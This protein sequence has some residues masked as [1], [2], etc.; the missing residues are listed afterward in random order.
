MDETARYIRAQ[1]EKIN[2]TNLR[3]HIFKLKK[4]VH[5]AWWVN[6]EYVTVNRKDLELLLNHMKQELKKESN[7]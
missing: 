6:C 4:L 7:G 5:A 1:Q 2:Y 3:S